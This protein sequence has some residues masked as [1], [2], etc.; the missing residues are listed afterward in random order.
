MFFVFSFLVL[1]VLYVVKHVLNVAIDLLF[2]YVFPAFLFIVLY[3]LV[4]Y[5]LTYVFIY[6]LCLFNGFNCY[7][8]FLFLNVLGF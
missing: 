8:G 4:V 2:F 6:V 5:S 3:I 7:R 1:Y